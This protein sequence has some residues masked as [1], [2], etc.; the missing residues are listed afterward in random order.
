MEVEV[1]DIALEINILL[2]C[3]KVLTLVHFSYLLTEKEEVDLQTR[4]LRFD[5]GLLTKRL[6]EASDWLKEQQQQNHTQ[7]DLLEQRGEAIGGVFGGG[8]QSKWTSFFFL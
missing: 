1:A 8:N 2:R 5:I 4:H 3:Y 7:K 6:I